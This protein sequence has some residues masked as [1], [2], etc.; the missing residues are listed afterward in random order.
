LLKGFALGTAF[1]GAIAA[2]ALVLLVGED[3]DRRIRG[4]LVSAHLRSLQSARLTDVESNDRHS[5]KPWFNGKLDVAPPVIDLTAK[6]FTLLGG[7]LDFLD[8][9][10][11][12]AIVYKR[13]RH[14]INL[15]VAPRA[16]SSGLGLRTETLQGFNV[17]HWSDQGLDFWAVSDIGAD[18]LAEFG[19]EFD[20]ALRRG[21]GA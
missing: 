17:R 7:R 11:A 1:S 9:K 5:V 15:F 10:A 16:R 12:A 13:R 21:D 2:S 20:A 3:R 19:S 4:D 18:E 8:G 14:V 6:G